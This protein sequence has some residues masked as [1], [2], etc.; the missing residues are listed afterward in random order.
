MFNQISGTNGIAGAS[1]TMIVLSK[2]NRTSPETLMS[3]TGRDVEADEKIIK[4][5]KNNYKWKLIGNSSE[6]LKEQNLTLYNNDPVVITI[7]ALLQDNPKGIYITASELLV[8]ISEITGVIP[9]QS[10]PATLSKYI[11]TIKYKLQEY[12]NIFFAPAN[13]NGGAGGRKLYFSIPSREL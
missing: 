1:D 3:I 13:S 8:K 10:T 12:D 6:L 2:H 11:N 9:K 7:K 5:N 4:F